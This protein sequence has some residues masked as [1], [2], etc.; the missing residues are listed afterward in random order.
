M[1]SIEAALSGAVSRWNAGDLDGYLELYDDT[2]KLHGYSAK[3]MDKVAVVRHYRKVWAALAVD[4]S[5]NPRLDIKDA[6][7]DGNRLACRFLMSGIHRGTFMGFPATGRP[8]LCQ[9]ITLMR[10]TG[11]RVVERWSI[12]DALNQLIQIDTLCPTNKSGERN[13]VPRKTHSF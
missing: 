10:F 12:T 8:Y 9:G 2:V 5:P 13:I 11:Q 7:S 6:L 1:V 4:G 3:P